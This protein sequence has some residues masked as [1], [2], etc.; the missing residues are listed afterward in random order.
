MKKL[1]EDLAKLTD[2]GSMYAVAKLLEIDADTIRNW[3]HRGSIPDTLTCYKIA[4][5]LG[6]DR[7]QLVIDLHSNYERNPRKRRA[8]EELAGKGTRATSLIAALLFLIYPPSGEDSLLIAQRSKS[9]PTW[10]PHTQGEKVANE[11][12]SHARKTLYIMSTNGAT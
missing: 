8:W 7:D 9:L 2:T 4:D 12:D 1:L 5:L 11:N 10:L 6:R 3:Q